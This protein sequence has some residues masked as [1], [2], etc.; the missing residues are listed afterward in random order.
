MITIILVTLILIYF[1]VGIIW[2][3]KLVD[4]MD[5]ATDM[6]RESFNRRLYIS[7]KFVGVIT[8]FVVLAS[9]IFWPL[10]QVSTIIIVKENRR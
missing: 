3:K 6:V 5:E 4:A 10:V 9:L 8:A 2:A 1:G 7:E